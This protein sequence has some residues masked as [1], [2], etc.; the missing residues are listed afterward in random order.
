MS[1]LQPVWSYQW[2]VEHRLTPIRPQ[3]TNS[4]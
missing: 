4:T 1:L 2:S 3:L